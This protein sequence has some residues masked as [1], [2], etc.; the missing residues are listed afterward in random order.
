LKVDWDTM[1]RVKSDMDGFRWVWF[2]F[3]PQN[4]YDA[5]VVF[6]GQGKT[7]RGLKGYIWSPGLAEELQRVKRERKAKESDYVF[8]NPDGR[9]GDIRQDTV[10]DRLKLYAE[11][12]GVR[13]D[14]GKSVHP[15]LIRAG[16]ALELHLKGVPLK[17]IMK[18]GH[19]R[20]VAALTRYLRI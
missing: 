3:K 7:G 9:R 11:E 5:T 18:M 10:E 8:L 15:H 14:G 4:G 12:A 16:A 1:G 2:Y 19:W 13:R 17:V 20:S 6:H